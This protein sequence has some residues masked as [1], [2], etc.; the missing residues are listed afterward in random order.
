MSSRSWC[1]EGWEIWL[2]RARSYGL[3]P[4]AVVG[5]RSSCGHVTSHSARDVLFRRLLG[6]TSGEVRT[7]NGNFGTGPREAHRPFVGGK[8]PMNAAS[9]TTHGPSPQSPMKARQR[10]AVTRCSA[11]PLGSGIRSRSTGAQLLTGGPDGNLHTG[12]SND[13]LRLPGLLQVK[14]R[15]GRDQKSAM[16]MRYNKCESKSNLGAHV[17]CGK[18]I[19]SDVS[20]RSCRWTNPTQRSR[21]SQWLVAGPPPKPNVI[22]P[23]VNAS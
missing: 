20:A 6:G 3:R 15:Q 9:K 4:R 17:A 11:L 18:D 13:E 19:G 23:S 7:V 16:Y 1:A 5:V 22:G 14:A 10:D 2:L 8:N 21:R 12:M